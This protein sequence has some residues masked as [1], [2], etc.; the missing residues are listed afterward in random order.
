MNADGFFDRDPRE[1]LD[2]LV[3]PGPGTARV[4]E[5]R[6]LALEFSSRGDRVPARLLLPEGAGPFPVVL[7][8]H[9]AGG[10]KEADY[11]DVA[12]SPW[13]RA[14]A[15]IASLDFPLHG[16]RAEAKLLT[17]L[18]AGRDRPTSLRLDFTRQA[19]VDLRRAVDALE[20]LEPVDA[21]RLV[22]AGFSLGTMLG[23]VFCAHDPR[24]R[25]AAFAIGGGG[26]GPPEVDP[27]A[28]VG[29]ISPRPVLF[30]NTRGDATIPRQAAEALHGAAREPKQIEWFD[31]THTELPGVA[32]KTMWTFLSGQLGLS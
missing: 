26:L 19:V 30:V 7:L 6:G 27:V 20:R 24:P 29:R 23:A 13:L 12:S 18:L 10:S 28:H 31:G 3:R 17:R 15:A 22:Y 1:P 11:L 16:E 14:G 8:Q 9:G 25:A 32:L 2:L 21:A 4:P 5:A